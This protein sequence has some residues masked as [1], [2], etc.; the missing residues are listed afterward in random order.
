MRKGDEKKQEMLRVAERL[1]CQ[2]GYEATSVQDI[3]DITH[4]SKGG[5]YHHFPSKD[6]L[7][8]ALCLERAL[9]ARD[10]AE[11]A[12]ENIQDP[13]S[14]LKL[15]LY[16]MTPLREGEQEFMAMLLPL[17][18]RPEGVTVR[19]R[20]QAALREAF[21]PLLKTAASQ[22]EAVACIFPPV[23]NGASLAATL[24]ERC[25]QDAALTLLADARAHRKAD[26]S[27][28][29]EGLESYRHAVELLL[30]APYG[31]IEIVRLEEWASMAER[32]LA[33]PQ[34]R[35]ET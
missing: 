30:G 12:V 16:W 7:L 27:L 31:S 32:M 5:F 2:R 34:W 13:L 9:N 28:L 33:H 4:A 35:E 6:A 1:F 23:R 8:D 21:L 10:A 19:V 25:W 29:L 24:V 20:Y 3:L 17:L 14:R 15:L 22:A 11:A 18:D 26:L